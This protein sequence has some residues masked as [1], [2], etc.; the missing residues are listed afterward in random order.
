MT[1]TAFPSFGRIIAIPTAVAE[2][3]RATTVA[4]RYGHP[5]HAEVARGHGPC[6]HCLRSFEIGVDRR[7][8]FTYDPFAGLESL[9][10]PG[11]VYIHEA[12]C[13]RYPEAGPFPGELREHRLTLTGF[14]R[15]RMYRCQ[16]YVEDGAVEAAILRLFGRAD[17][18][19]VHVSDTEAGCFDLRVERRTD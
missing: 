5:A 12:W 7:V 1:A 4:P 11:P 18:D 10:Q 16:E 8:L 14:G 9:P 15:G 13:E 2:A 19:Y 6:R 3:V 17:V